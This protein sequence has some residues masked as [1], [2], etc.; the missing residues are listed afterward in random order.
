MKIF[1]LSAL[2]FLL[3]SNLVWAWQPFTLENQ[4]SIPQKVKVGC[5]TPP[6]TLTLDPKKVETIKPTD[7]PCNLTLESWG[8]NAFPYRAMPEEAVAIKD[9][10]IIEV[11]KPIGSVK[12]I[13]KDPKDYD[14]E[15]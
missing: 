3:F 5:V 10:K 8:P 11:T 15:L 12:I 13:N 1:S 2:V 4:E 14:M 9:G 6:T 7:V